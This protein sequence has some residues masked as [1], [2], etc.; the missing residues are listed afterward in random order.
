MP[1]TDFTLETVLSRFDIEL[2]H[3]AL[4]TPEQRKSD[5]PPVW[6]D[7]TLKRGEALALGS[8]KAR[9]EF[10]VAPMLL[11]LREMSGNAIAIYSGLRF[12][13]APEQG[14]AGECDFI[15]SDSEPFPIIRSPIVSVVEAKKNDLDLGWGQCASQMVASLQ[16]NQ[17]THPERQTVYGCITTGREWQFVRLCNNVMTIDIP[18]FPI[19]QKELILATF[20]A[21]LQ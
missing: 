3:E 16:F 19:V 18:V 20:L 1:Y 12:D 2:K 8:E 6:L 14:L 21:M 10:I 15:L 5:S 17:R 7:D 9:S 13:V 11:S 4:F